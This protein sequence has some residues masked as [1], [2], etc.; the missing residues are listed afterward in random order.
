MLSALTYL[1]TPRGPA[2]VDSTR[3]RSASDLGS[4]GE[5]TNVEELSVDLKRDESEGTRICP[6]Q[7]RV[8][9]CMTCNSLFVRYV[10]LC[11]HA[12]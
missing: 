4:E 1:I 3:D 7:V 8:M 11:L 10:M 12:V 9:L 6:P 5:V 2:V